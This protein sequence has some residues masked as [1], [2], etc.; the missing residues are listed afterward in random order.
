MDRE[1]GWKFRPVLTMF[2]HWNLI[3]NKK[4]ANGHRVF[5]ESASVARNVPPESSWTK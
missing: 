1:Q 2:R 5:R 3:E 4:P